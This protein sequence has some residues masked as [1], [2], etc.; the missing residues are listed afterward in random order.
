[1]QKGYDFVSYCKRRGMSSSEPCSMERFAEYGV[2]AQQ[3]LV[4][5]VEDVQ[6]DEVRKEGEGFLLTLATGEEVRARRVAVAV[7][8][9]N[10]R[11]VPRELQIDSPRVSHTSQ[12][13]DY[14]QFRGMDIVVIGGG[15]SALEAGGLLTQ[16]GATARILIRGNGTWFADKMSPDR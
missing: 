16:H 7:G 1:P 6:V 9:A 8:L 2:W 12:I 15:Q 4:P 10:F 5:E 13:R 14:E 11:R 3:E